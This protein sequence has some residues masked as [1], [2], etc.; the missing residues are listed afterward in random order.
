ME[1]DQS[2]RVQSCRI[3]PHPSHEPNK[4]TVCRCASGQTFSGHEFVQAT[5][6]TTYCDRGDC[7]KHYS[8]AIHH[9]RGYACPN[10]FPCA[11]CVTAPARVLS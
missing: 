11:V 7:R 5:P 2:G 10:G 3:C 6:E 9:R 4:C 8:E 1:P